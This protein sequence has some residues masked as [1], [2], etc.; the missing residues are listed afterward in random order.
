MRTDPDELFDVV[1]ASDRVLRQERRSVV[2]ASGLL[3]RAV[4]CFVLD[5]E[6]RLLLQLRSASKD[7]FPSRWSTSVS[8]HLDAGESYG[9]AALRELG[10]ELGVDPPP[11][12][13][14]RFLGKSSPSEATEH[15]FVACYA[16]EWTDEVDPPADEVAEVRWF[17]EPEL[18]SLLAS[19]PD[20]FTPSLR[21]L[22]A[23]HRA[24]LGWSAPRTP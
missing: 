13:H 15:E 9:A 1:D 8:G 23:L 20:S 14:L 21:H 2:H 10:E 6:G 17:A 22:L 11:G 12:L 18:D 19:Q 4:H 24:S 5:D 16:A 7:R 3:H